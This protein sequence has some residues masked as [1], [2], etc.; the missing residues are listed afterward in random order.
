MTLLS[1][2]SPGGVGYGGWHWPPS[3]PKRSGDFLL[4]FSVFG[5]GIVSLVRETC[6]SISVAGLRSQI[7]ISKSPGGRRCLDL[8]R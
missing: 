6:L 7:V 5:G 2:S 3:C 8:S 1:H 4:R